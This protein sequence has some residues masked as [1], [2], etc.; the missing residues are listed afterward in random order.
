M[1]LMATACGGSPT[2]PTTPP[3]PPGAP[4]A[5]AI[6]AAV[7]QAYLRE[8]GVSI[9]RPAIFNDA[10][11]VNCAGE[12]HLTTTAYFRSGPKNATL[13]S[14]YMSRDGSTVTSRQPVTSVIAP[15]GTFR[16]LVVVVGH[17]QT[18]GAESLMLLGIGQSQINEDHATFARRKGYSGPIVSFENTN[19]VIDASRIADP[20]SLASVLSSAGG[21]GIGTAGYDFVMSLNIDPSRSEGGFAIP[22]TGFLYVGNFSNWRTTLGGNDWA[23]IAR[24]A[25]HHEVA[26][27]WGWPGTHDWSSTCG[28]TRLG[29]EPLIAAPVLFGWEDVD[30]D[31]VPE[32]LDATPYG[33]S[34]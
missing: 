19:V 28:G 34:P 33:R 8:F 21:Q 2:G 22:G 29:F 32:I 13:H 15:A 11:S 23:A 16:A 9:T 31:G 20:R 25:Y 27:H 12:G 17:A 26:H 7:S 3:A 30:G 24:T 18:V 4:P 14:L 5:T 10:R 1:L 6:E